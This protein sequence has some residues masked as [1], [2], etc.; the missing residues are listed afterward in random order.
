MNGMDESRDQPSHPDVLSQLLKSIALTA[1]EEPDCRTTSESVAGIAESVAS[2]ADLRVIS[3][4]IAVHLEH[5]LNCRD[6][7]ESLV[8]IARES[9]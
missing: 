8:E 7:F 1:D 4:D 2:G 5:C 9:E 3:P 6:L